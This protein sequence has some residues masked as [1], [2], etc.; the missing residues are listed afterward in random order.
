MTV[1][2]PIPPPRFV[3][4]SDLDQ[5]ILDSYSDL[6]SEVTTLVS[7][8]VSHMFGFLGKCIFICI[9]NGTLNIFIRF[10]NRFSNIRAKILSVNYQQHLVLLIEIF[11][12]QFL[13]VC[14][15][16]RSLLMYVSLIQKVMLPD[17]LVDHHTLT[18]DQVR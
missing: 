4:R 5:V 6:L 17:E 9:G 1:E 7:T 13:N 18:L 16:F 2:P 3:N 15:I 8:H 10:S 11:V 14:H 12:L